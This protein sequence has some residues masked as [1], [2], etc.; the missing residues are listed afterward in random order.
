MSQVHDSQPYTAF[1]ASN[2]NG[3]GE[4]HDSVLGKKEK[5]KVKLDHLEDE[6]YKLSHLKTAQANIKIF[7]FNSY[8]VGSWVFT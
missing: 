2:E 1:I 6:K 4:G 8:D 5:N 7:P 3:P